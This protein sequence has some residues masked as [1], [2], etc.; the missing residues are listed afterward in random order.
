VPIGRPVANTRIYVLDPR[1]EPVPVG[2]AGEL[3]IGA[4]RWGEVTSDAPS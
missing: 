3:H 4:S 2:V 1:L